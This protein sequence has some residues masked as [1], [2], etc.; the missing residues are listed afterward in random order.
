MIISFSKLTT[1]N[2]A[3]L[4]Q[5]VITIS[6]A[7]SHAVVKDH[8]LL[9]ALQAANADYD[10]VYAK[11]AFSGKGVQVGDAD[12][13]R[14]DLHGGLKS[15][16]MGYSRINGFALQQDA[17]DI[18]AVMQKYGVELERYSYSEES[19]QLRKLIEELAKPENVTKL[20]H[21][22]LTEVVANL[23]LAQ[24]NFER[25]FMEQAGANAELRQME[26]ATSLRQHLESAIRNYLNVVKAMNPLPGWKEL[27][28]EIDE[29]VKAV[30]NSKM[31]TPK[32]DSTTAVTQ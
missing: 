13:Q 31:D 4:G 24:E 12:A 2:L 7:A 30:R 15:V 3:T 17:I 27:Y 14:D 8:P 29:V 21:L 1:K 25:V 9:L 16:V 5:R 10:A 19:A 11:S 26:S 6:N 18:Y 32:K 23:K 28:A 22:Q 20:Q